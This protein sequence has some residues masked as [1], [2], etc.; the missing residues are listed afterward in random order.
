MR[1]YL[2]LLR[3]IILRLLFFRHF[4]LL[5][6]FFQTKYVYV[7]SAICSLFSCFSFLLFVRLFVDVISVDVKILFISFFG[8]LRHLHFAAVHRRPDR[9]WKCSS[10]LCWRCQ[11]LRNHPTTDIVAGNHGTFP[12]IGCR[13][14]SMFAFWMAA[15]I[16]SINC[17][18]FERWSLSLGMTMAHS[19]WGFSMV[20]GLLSIAMLV[21]SLRSTHLAW[22]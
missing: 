8:F 1:Q 19:W 10:C 16:Y 20:S 21:L 6:Y 13:W 12:C 15:H 2:L 3:L 18:A 17:M 14:C 4:F 11:F 7:S 22:E 5:R 9:Y